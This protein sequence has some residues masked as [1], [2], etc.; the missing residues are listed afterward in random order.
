MLWMMKRRLSRATCSMLAGKDHHD[1]RLLSRSEEYVAGT[2][3]TPLRRC[4]QRAQPLDRGT[5]TMMLLMPRRLSF[6]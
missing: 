4:L 5:P 3:L 2:R 6:S 1:K